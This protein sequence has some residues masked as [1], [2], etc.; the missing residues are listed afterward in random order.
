MI[1][2]RNGGERFVSCLDAIGE[3]RPGPE[4]LVVIDSGSDDGTPEAARAFGADVTSITPQTFDHGVTRNQAAAALPDVD[5]VVFLVQDAIP[6]GEDWLSTLALAATQPG[7]AAAT[8]RQVPPDEADYL[9][10][11]TVFDSPFATEERRLTG[12]F[13]ALQLRGFEARDWRDVVLLDNVCCAIRGEL[14]R[15]TGFR[16]TR[17]G[18]DVLMAY[19]LLWSGWALAHEPDAVVEHGHEYDP[20]SV[21]E[22]YRGDA[23]FFRE[24]FGLRV[25]PS[26]WSAV[27]GLVYELRRDLAWL[28][29]FPEDRGGG[30]M[31]R[32]LAL[33]WAQVWAQHRGSRGPL[34]IL[35]DRRDVPRPEQLRGDEQGEHEQGEDE[36]PRQRRRVRRK[37]VSGAEGAA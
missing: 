21:A 19:D 35:P 24:R 26:R 15:R 7:V 27:R 14:F 25:R 32:S 6:L 1:P 12:P 16:P 2:T 34:G 31:R 8:A 28:R 5:V 33:R 36:A 37:P 11:S 30:A 23:K 10:C 20:E 29:E 22:R 18:E 3:Q 17:H 4:A 9:T 13:E